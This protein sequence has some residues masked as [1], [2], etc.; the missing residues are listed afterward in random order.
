MSTV[1]SGSF[2]FLALALAG[3]LN[4]LAPMCLFYRPIQDWGQLSLRNDIQVTLVH[5]VCLVEKY[6]MATAVKLNSLLIIF[7]RIR[8][9][10]TGRCLTTMNDPNIYNSSSQCHWDL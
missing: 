7:I 3:K 4:L 6:P 8:A 9:Y 2:C 1:I 5:E 10:S